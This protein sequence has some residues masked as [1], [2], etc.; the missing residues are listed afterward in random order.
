MGAK[1]FLPRFSK[2]LEDGTLSGFMPD[3]GSN[4]LVLRAS[5]ATPVGQRVAARWGDIYANSTNLKGNL[6]IGQGSLSTDS[7]STSSQIT[8][9]DDFYIAQMTATVLKIGTGVDSS[10]GTIILSYDVPTNNLVTEGNYIG[11]GS[12]TCTQFKPSTANFIF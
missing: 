2:Y 6:L 9:G 5:S 4:T 11:A 10:S 3:I 8:F 1:H 12:I 7:T